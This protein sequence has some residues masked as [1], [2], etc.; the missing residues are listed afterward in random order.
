MEAVLYTPVVSVEF[1]QAA[2]SGFPGAGAGNSIDDFRCDFVQFDPGYFT[3]NTKDLSYVGEIEVIIELGTGP[4]LADLKTAMPF[5]DGLVMR[6]GKR[7]GS[8]PRYPT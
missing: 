5:I 6:G 2:G 4:D 8:K 7:S 1:K 3:A